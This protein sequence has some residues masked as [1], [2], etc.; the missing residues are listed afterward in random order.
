MNNDDLDDV[1][2]ASGADV[3]AGHRTPAAAP[4]TDTV[5]ALVQDWISSQNM[6]IV[7]LVQECIGSGMD[8][9]TECDNS[10]MGSG[11]DWFRNGF[12]SQNVTI[13]GLI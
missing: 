8:W 9:F 10:R 11:M 6:T 7:E 2:C 5:V 3:W 1:S 13:V 4:S 12:V